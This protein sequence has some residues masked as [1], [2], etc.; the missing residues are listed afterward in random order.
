MVDRDERLLG[1]E[2]DRLGGGEADDHAADQAGT[3]CRRDPVERRERELRLDHRLR[4]DMV[5]RLDVRA[6][7]DL[8]HH[9]AVGL[10][11]GGLREHDVGEDFAAPIVAAPHHCGSSLV[12][13]R[14]DAEN[15]HVNL[16]SSSRGAA[17]GRVSKDDPIFGYKPLIPP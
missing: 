8:R 16:R 5:E 2:R 4:D 6:G 17:E 9:A 12:A 7:R 14:L 3:G 11:F 15:E 10:V 13:G 1:D